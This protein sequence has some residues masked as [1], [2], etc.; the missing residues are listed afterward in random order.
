MK[1]LKLYRNFVKESKFTENHVAIAILGAPAAGKSYMVD[2]LQKLSKVSKLNKLDDILTKGINLTV[3]KLRKEFQSNNGKEQLKGF[4]NAYIW[5]RDQYEREP[6]IYEKWFNDIKKTWIKFDEVSDEITTFVSN[7]N[8]LVVNNKT[9]PSEI[10]ELIYQLNVN[11]VDKMISFLDSYSDYKRVVRWFQNQKQKEG[12][13]LQRDLVF[14]EAGDEPEKIVSRFKELRSGD[15][16]YVTSVFLIHGKS[17]VTNLIQNAGRMTSGTDEGRDSSGAIVQAWNDIENQIDIYKNSS[18]N[19]VIINADEKEIT[20]LFEQLKI[21][22]TEDN[23][24]L[25]NSN[26]S[27]DLFVN[28]L[29][30]EP[31]AAYDRTCKNLSKLFGNTPEMLELSLDLFNA[32]LLY[33]SINL[34]VDQNSK[35][36]VRKLVPG[37]ITENNIYDIF[38]RAI[39]SGKFNH[40]LNNL[41]KIYKSGKVVEGINYSNFGN[42]YCDMDGVVVDFKSFIEQ[43]E[44]NFSED[45]SKIPVRAFSM[46]NK[47]E[48]ADQIV[49]FIK[50]RFPDFKFLSA[51]PKKH[52]GEISHY[53]IT[54][55]KSWIKENFGIE[56]DRVIV[57]DD[58]SKKYL[59][60]VNEQGFANILIDDT[61]STIEKW[62]QSG[63]KGIYYQNFLQMVDDLYKVLTG[64]N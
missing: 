29:P 42:L 35:M 19:S 57:V 64:L 41:D 2:L 11:E 17:P 44:P 8:K 7:D 60:A 25:K 33:H 38:K 16:P 28:I 63:G 40:P 15:K 23:S 12:Q 43:Y 30:Q 18:E 53:S 61:F 13:N 54:D 49:D 51:S 34:N 36:E 37:K 26:K 20:K 3:D 55:K 52:R 14:D 6:K 59:Y 50:Q 56:E 45:W 46:M 22:T 4:F 32:I 10:Y 48:S 47:T 39:E 24:S 62:N 5:L 1:Y 21:I 9:T 27:I 31:K 58:K